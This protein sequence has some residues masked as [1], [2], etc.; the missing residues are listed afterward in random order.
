MEKEDDKSEIAKP[1]LFLKSI[2]IQSWITLSMKT[3]TKKVF[4]VDDV[5]TA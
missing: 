4:A 3:G 2:I 1:C 5:S